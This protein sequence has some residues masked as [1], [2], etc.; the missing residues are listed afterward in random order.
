[1]RVLIKIFKDLCE[2][3]QGSLRI[4][5]DPK[6]ILIYFCEDLQES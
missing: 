5:E 6:K 1:M 2:D 3:P 4:L